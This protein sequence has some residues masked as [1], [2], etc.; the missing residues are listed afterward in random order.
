MI[1]VRLVPNVARRSELLVSLSEYTSSDDSR[2]ADVVIREPLGPSHR[3][4]PVLREQ[5]VRRI[6]APPPVLFR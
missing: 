5:C 2:R 1:G 6:H 3:Q 4:L